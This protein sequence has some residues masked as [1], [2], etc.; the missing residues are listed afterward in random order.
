[1][2]WVY[3]NGVGQYDEKNNLVREFVCK[4]DVI[5][6]MTMSDKTLAKALEK[7]IKYNGF[8][9]RLLGSRTKCL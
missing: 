9:Y 7:E 4:Y 3:K 2:V 5:K 1:M 8:S 6:R